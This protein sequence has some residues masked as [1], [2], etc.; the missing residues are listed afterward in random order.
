MEKDKKIVHL[1]TLDLSGSGRAAMRIVDAQCN[2]GWDSLLL[3]L[4]KRSKNAS[5][6][7]VKYDAP[8]TSLWKRI[9][10]KLHLFTPAH[11][12]VAQRL[13]EYNVVDGVAVLHSDCQTEKN[14]II[15]Q[16]DVINLHWVRDF[17]DI[18]DFLNHTT[19]PI[20][21][22]L[23]DQGPY[24]GCCCYTNV[25]ERYLDTC[26]CCPALSSMQDED[27]STE[28]W[29]EKYVLYQ[30][31]ASR[32]HIVCCSNWMADGARKSGLMKHLDI[33]VIP[34]CIDTNLFVP[35]AASN[36]G[37][38]ISLLFGAMDAKDIHKGYLRL[39]NV[40]ERMKTREEF[41]I[42]DIEILILGENSEGVANL[43]YPVRHLGFINDDEALVRVYQESSLLL[44][45]SYRDNLPNMIMESMACGTPVVSF[46]VGGI[47]DLIDHEKNG[48]LAQTQDDFV[49]GVLWSLQNRSQLSQ[50]AREKV[51]CCFT[52][53][54]VTEQYIKCYKEAL[55]GKT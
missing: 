7:V 32:L 40:L 8:K 26:G 16:A 14:A 21:W 45:A 12:E 24:T 1:N 43:P 35:S 23:H 39:V 34:N 31:H 36:Y 25:C 38:K 48:Y 33:R 9:L 20:V 3:C 46:N 28:L 54:V 37:N 41:A 30:K 6:N 22:T 10:K 27:Y 18:R 5:K 50:A 13:S 2:A 44:Y 17:V 52:P 55:Y 53:E 15:K 49:D 51:M 4:F 29:R 19:Q 42:Y 47:G 11:I